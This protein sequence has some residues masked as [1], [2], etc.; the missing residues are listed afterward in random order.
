MIFHVHNGS[1]Y[2]VSLSVACSVYSHAW[3]YAE[4]YRTC[5]AV[6]LVH[7]LPSPPFLNKASPYFLSSPLLYLSPSWYKAVLSLA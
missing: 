4:I 3:C 1:P 5:N 6:A 2:T 7:N